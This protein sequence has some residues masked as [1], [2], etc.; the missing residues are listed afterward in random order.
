MTDSEPNS[1][2][3]LHHSSGPF[4]CLRRFAKPPVA[5][6]GSSTSLG[7]CC[8]K[9]QAYLECQSKRLP[10]AWPLR[11][12]WEQFYDAYA[13]L[14]RRFAVTCGVRDV[15]LDDCVQQVLTEV[16]GSLGSFHH[17]SERAQF[18]SWLYAL[19][20]S[21]ATDLLR[22]RVR[23]PAEPLSEAA[24]TKLCARDGDPAAAYERQRQRATVQLAWSGE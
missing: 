14:I 16:I 10:A 6:R 21:R 20:H 5:G 24:A 22:Y 13:P 1:A 3:R 4:L 19:V 9:R 11:R 18:R 2:R 12:A 7:N 8:K 23:H 15:D 17:D